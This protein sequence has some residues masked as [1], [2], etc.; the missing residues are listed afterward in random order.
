MNFDHKMINHYYK[1]FGCGAKKPTA[2]D[3]VLCCAVVQEVFECSDCL[4]PFATKTKA[5]THWNERH[6]TFAAPVTRPDAAAAPPA[7][8][9]DGG[10]QSY[11]GGYCNFGTI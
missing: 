4:E 2:D 10:S 5:E 7:E 9:F 6:L 1:C 3:A 8:D 11:A